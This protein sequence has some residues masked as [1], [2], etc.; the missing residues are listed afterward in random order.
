MIIYRAVKK[1]LLK[2][3]DNMRKS[4]DKIIKQ[5]RGS[6]FVL[7]E[8]Q[9]PWNKMVK[10][11]E[12]CTEEN[13]A[14]TI[15]GTSLTIIRLLRVNQEKTFVQDFRGLINGL[16]DQTSLNIAISSGDKK[17]TGEILRTWEHKKPI[18]SNDINLIEKIVYSSSEHGL[19]FLQ[20]FDPELLANSA[21]RERLAKNLEL[22]R[23]KQTQKK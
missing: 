6:R 17:Q 4:T 11:V 7:P 9:E 1:D 22:A 16:V 5:F 19:T 13:R 15:L 20:A 14:R 12:N 3:I 2:G 18:S 21:I 23:K 8:Q 10:T